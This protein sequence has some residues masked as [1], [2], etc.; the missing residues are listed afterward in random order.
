MSLRESGSLTT[1]CIGAASRGSVP[2]NQT[3]GSPLARRT[4]RRFEIH[5]AEF[6]EASGRAVSTLTA[7]TRVSVLGA[8]VLG[9]LM[10]RPR[11]RSARASIGCG[12]V[13]ASPSLRS[14]GGGLRLVALLE[15]STTSLL[16]A[17][18]APASMTTRRRGHARAYAPFEGRRLSTSGRW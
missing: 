5:L 16:G 14:R 4:P 10:Y 3:L 6:A 8:C 12:W 17:P 1:R 13:R 2:S 7:V 18:A 15:P 11:L 9:G